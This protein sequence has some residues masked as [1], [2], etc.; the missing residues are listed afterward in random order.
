MTTAKDEIRQA[1]EQFA[2]EH[3]IVPE[4]FFAETDLFVRQDVSIRVRYTADDGVRQAEVRRP[5]HAIE[6]IA[7]KQRR[8]RVL[9]VLKSEDAVPVAL[10]IEEADATLSEL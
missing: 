7:E 8:Q 9:A 3:A 10:E 2:W 4:V 6:L 1:G 5:G